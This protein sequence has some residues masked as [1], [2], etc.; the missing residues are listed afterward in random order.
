MKKTLLIAF[1]ILSFF[2]GISTSRAYNNEVSPMLDLTNIAEFE[3]EQKWTDEQYQM[4]LD[5]KNNYCQGYEHYIFTSTNGWI[6]SGNSS[7]N[8]LNMYCFNGNYNDVFFKISKYSSSSNYYT[9]Q[10]LIEPYEQIEFRKGTIKDNSYIEQNNNGQL[11]KDN[12]SYGQIN[13][14]LISGNGSINSKTNFLI[15]YIE[16]DLNVGKFSNGKVSYGS[17]VYNS[18]K[19]NGII[20]NVGDKFIDFENKYFFSPSIDYD[21]SYKENRQLYSLDFYFKSEDVSLNKNFEIDIENLDLTQDIFDL[22]SFEFYGLVNE[23]GLYHWEDIYVANEMG[24]HENYTDYEITYKG[25]GTE[26]SDNTGFLLKIKDLSLDFMNG[27]YEKIR[28]SITFKN[29]KKYKLNLKSYY[30][31]TKDNYYYNILGTEKFVLKNNTKKYPY[32]IF[33]T[34]KD[35]VVSALF[36]DYD[37]KNHILYSSYFNTNDGYSGDTIFD[38]DSQYTEM[39][40]TVPLNIGLTNKQGFWISS[41]HDDYFDYYVYYN[42]LDIYYSLNSNHDLSDSIYID[43]TGTQV[44]LPL[45]PQEGDP[46]RDDS[47]ISYFKRAFKKFSK[48]ITYILENISDFFRELPGVFQDYYVLIF[49]FI[50]FVIVLKF[51]L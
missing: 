38:F 23:N 18:I 26:F 15:P 13:I 39:I 12:T 45:I 40:D 21:Y 2:V 27:K 47:L 48:I 25:T 33:S 10:F 11:Y 14:K 7:G 32:L 43:D 42:G 19:Y 5:W 17:Y 50:I 35:S 36:T 6:G 34:K 9:F 46:Y 29:A 31:L 24:T 22:D 44:E 37:N 30:D 8:Y 41:N 16:S 49:G 4:A 20:Y 1:I 28:F 3:F 51:I